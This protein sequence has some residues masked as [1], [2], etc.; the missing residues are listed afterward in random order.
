MKIELWPVLPPIYLMMGKAANRGVF[1]EFD[2]SLGQ[3]LQ[4]LINVLP[5]SA[6]IPKEED[7]QLQK[8]VATL[9]QSG[10]VVDE[11][12]PSFRMSAKSLGE[13]W[14]C[15]QDP[16][17]PLMVF[18]ELSE[19]VLR[20]DLKLLYGQTFSDRYYDL[21]L[22]RFTQWVKN[23]ANGQ[24]IGFFDD[25]G[26][27]LRQEIAD[28]QAHPDLYE[29]DR[30]VM[31]VYLASGALDRH[32]V[33]DVV[34]LLSMTLMAAVFN[35]QISL[36]WILVHLYSDAELL[37][38]ARSEIASCRNADAYVELAGESFYI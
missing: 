28:R 37:R 34:G 10:T 11:L 27:C 38:R 20:A 7:V 26:G 25:L 22:P 24:L 16:C 23:I 5:V 2:S 30:S 8:R 9:F 12:L 36:A 31:Q 4:E 17:R 15:P 33:D 35:T 6:R 19:Y 3:I 14:M 1:S 18:F 29:D 32:A 13:K 21:I